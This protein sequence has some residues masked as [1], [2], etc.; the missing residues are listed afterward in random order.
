[1]LLRQ[2]KQ[3]N[4]KI[5]WY[6]LS[7]CYVP[8][9]VLHN[10]SR[11]LL[12]MHRWKDSWDVTFSCQLKM[13]HHIPTTRQNKDSGHPFPFRHHPAFANYIGLQPR[14]TL[15][16]WLPWT[17]KEA[18]KCSLYLLFHMNWK[19]YPYQRERVHSEGQESISPAITPSSGFRC[20]QTQ[21]FFNVYISA[22]ELWPR[23]SD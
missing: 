15:I 3:T 11:Y 1:M 12:N 13:A 21:F 22:A 10:N 19:F 5:N 18:E 14:K 9:S 17:S 7:M 4:T 6:L 8:E 16:T 2:P 20:Y 23:S